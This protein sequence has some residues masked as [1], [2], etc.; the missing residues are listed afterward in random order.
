MHSQTAAVIPG[1]LLLSNRAGFMG[2]QWWYMGWG[3][4]C[5]AFFTDSL[6]S[7]GDRFC[8]LL[9]WP[10]GAQPWL[11]FCVCDPRWAGLLGPCVLSSFLRRLSLLLLP[12]V[13]FSHQP[14]SGALSLWVW[15]LSSS[16]AVET[17]PKWVEDPCSSLSGDDGS[18]QGWQRW[19][20]P[21]NLLY[22]LG[23]WGLL[24]CSMA[25]V[26][27][28]GSALWW[29][30][31]PQGSGLGWARSFSALVRSPHQNLFYIP[32]PWKI[33]LVLHGRYTLLFGISTILDSLSC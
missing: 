28:A 7:C 13:M 10:K 1:Y 25:G 24:S 16:V 32:L 31:R 20:T 22:R 3:F 9:C 21:P 14:S 12:Q 23:V 4:L 2:I 18:A 19:V 26:A 8:R 29:E 30:G 17:L 5:A 33:R 27:T 15:S 6:L 11:L